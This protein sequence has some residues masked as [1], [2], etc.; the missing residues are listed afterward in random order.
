MLL[1]FLAF[2]LSRSLASLE[3]DWVL[4]IFCLFVV[5][6]VLPLFGLPFSSCYACGSSLSLS[7]YLLL[8]FSFVSWFSAFLMFCILYVL[9]S[10]CSQ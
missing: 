1:P 5:V 7:V 6:V 9:F 8:Y 2:M 3:K 10:L 4:V